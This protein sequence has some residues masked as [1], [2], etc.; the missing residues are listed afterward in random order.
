MIKPLLRTIPTMAGNVKLVCNLVDY[1]RID[2][3]T[4]EA[5]IRKA[6]L[7]PL[8]SSL[9]QS[10]QSVNLLSSSYEYDLKKFYNT[11]SDIFF[12]DVFNI[13]TKEIPFLN[14]SERLKNR[15]TDLEFG[16][17]RVSYGK[18]GYQY[19]FFAPI[20]IDSINDIPDYFMIDLE[21]VSRRGKLNKHLKVN[22]GINGSSDKNYIYKYLH[23]YLSKIDSNVAFMNNSEMSVSYYGIDLLSGGFSKKTDVTVSSLFNTQLPIQMFDQT[24]S[25][26]FKRNRMCIKQII[27]LCFYFNISDIL[28]EGE[29]SKYNFGSVRFTGSYYKGTEKLDLYDF[30]WDYDFH[31]ESILKMNKNTGIMSIIPGYVDNIMDVGFPSFN[32]RWLSKYS[33][34]NKLSAN[35]CRWKLM[36]SSDEFPYITNMSWAFSKNQDSNYKYREYP[37]SYLYQAGY[38]N[39]TK[40]NK[41]NL[42]FPLGKDIDVYNE[43]NEKSADKYAAIM[44]NYCLNW[45]DIVKENFNIDDI[46]WVDVIDG[47]AYFNSI[48]Y[49]FNSIY[50]KLQNFNSS[51]RIDKFAMLLYPDTTNIYGIN[52]LRDDI[53]YVDR[54]I[55]VKTQNNAIDTNVPVDTNIY[56]TASAKELY[57]VNSENNAS[58]SFNGIF[59]E[60]NDDYTGIKYYNPHDIGYEYYNI[61]SYVKLRNL[62]RDIFS[63][64]DWRY[65]NKDG[66]SYDRENIKTYSD[67]TDELITK[68]KVT[69]TG[70]LETLEIYNISDT[71]KDALVYASFSNY[72]D[73]KVYLPENLF[74]GNIGAIECYEQLPIYR[75][76]MIT[77]EGSNIDESILEYIKDITI[78]EPNITAENYY[79]TL[80]TNSS[81][82]YINSSSDKFEPFKIEVNESG[83]YQLPNF[84]NANVTYNNMLYIK[85][86]FI[87]TAVYNTYTQVPYAILKNYCK[88][89]GDTPTSEYKYSDV[90][91]PGTPTNDLY[92]SID[93]LCERIFDIIKDSI[94]TTYN[95]DYKYNYNP[96]LNYGSSIVGTNIMTKYEKH[97]GVCSDDTIY[98]NEFNDYEIDDNVLYIHPYNIDTL[99][100]AINKLY[101]PDIEEGDLKKAELYSK[102]LDLDFLSKMVSIYDDGTYYKQYKV[103]VPEN[104]NILVKNKF[105]EIVDISD[106]INTAKFDSEK[107][108]FYDEN[109][110]DTVYYNIVHNDNYYKLDQNLWNLANIDESREIFEDTI[111]K[112]VDM[113]IYRPLRD[114]E[115]DEKYSD[116]IKVKYDDN[117]TIDVTD[118]DNIIYPCFNSFYRQDRDE[119][120]IYK[121]YSLDNISDVN[122]IEGVVTINKYYRYNTNNASVYIS[123]DDNI[124]L[125]D[126]VTK[127][128]ILHE[129]DLVELYKTDNN[130]FGLNIIED[131]GIRYGY[132]LIKVNMN[133]TRD[134]FNIR[135]L[136]DTD[137][138][139]KGISEIDQIQNLKYI[140]HINGVDIT[141][142]KEYL[143]DI[144]RQLCPFLYINLLSCTA[145]LG[146][147]MSP[148]AFNLTTT[149]S[150]VT[151]KD[152]IENGI[153]ERELV[154]NKQ[155]ITSAKKQILQRYTNAIIPYIKKCDLIKNQ[156][157]YKFKDVDTTLIETG[158]YYSIGDSTIYSSFKGIN[159]IS[160]YNVYSYI[161]D[162]NIKSYNNIVDVY[163]PIEHKDYNG[164]I[165]INLPIEFEI[166]NNKVYPYAQLQDME[167]NYETLLAFSNYL[168]TFK[169]FDDSEIL[170]LYNKYSVSYITSTVGVTIDNRQKTYKL[171]YKFNLL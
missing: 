14:K 146:T 64:S 26:G 99:V 20:Y 76:K 109:D 81:Y 27:P 147:L 135:G 130:L 114:I 127:Y 71:V 169:D 142:K 58:L 144:F 18:S 112:Y 68:R 136:L 84:D 152:N 82:V 21:I 95:G 16:T 45:F 160:G 139:S 8:S 140:T 143:I 42:I 55:T 80:Y 103:I 92:N 87:N 74:T 168:Q 12:S 110:T 52:K 61:N 15:N 72:D 48:L 138:N 63:L 154:Y 161:N 59:E 62:N 35:Y 170:F 56:N 165:G 57:N 137:E 19:A 85:D 118:T 51:D 131:N 155:T 39:I 65:L 150:S 6:N 153:K 2:N 96:I 124:N 132:Y 119:T 121:N 107:G 73:N 75:G 44:N 117:E 22:I 4:I 128:K 41:Y 100:E 93:A 97:F 88:A 158:K 78:N 50:N 167:S 104:D 23:K 134:M 120:I 70:I 106:F 29:R 86:W 123:V 122:I 94:N 149:Y 79:E 89:E 157:N 60:A 159:D 10:M 77:S 164:S 151:N 9:F 40:D 69:L 148:A 46:N 25:E 1:N 37:A 54:V 141:E 36:Y 115:F 125:P 67:I 166:T 24:L 53:K 116:Y 7:I 30:D 133:N 101:N 105:E 129:T 90:M 162:P 47:Y 32:D 126:T 163:Y 13:S 17:K 3:D 91:K 145:D 98:K 156:Y 83:S 5:N 33:Y 43:I 34:S 66:S 102:V 111:A 49:N 171:T 31:N 108:L 28:T 38:A 11:Y 113:Y